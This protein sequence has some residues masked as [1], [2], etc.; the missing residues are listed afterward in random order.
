MT[1]RSP[2]HQYHNM[3]LEERRTFAHWLQ[4]NAIIGSTFAAALIGMAIVGSNSPAPHQAAAGAG[5]PTEFS[6]SQRASEH[7]SPVPVYDL[8]IQLAPTLPLQ[9]VDEP[10]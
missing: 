8:M 6:G 1:R 7:R 3:S 2:I 5:K 9:Q 4:A 10:Y